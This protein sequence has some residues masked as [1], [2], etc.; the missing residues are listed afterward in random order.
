MPA[1]IHDCVRPWAV[2]QLPHIESGDSKRG[3]HLH[4]TRPTGT[5]RPSHQFDTERRSGDRQAVAGNGAASGA[6]QRGRL[7]VDRNCGRQ[8]RP[9]CRV[10][11]P[12]AGYQPAQQDRLE[13]SGGANLSRHYPRPAR[14]PWLRGVGVPVPQMRRRTAFPHRSTRLGLYPVRLFRSDRTARC[15]GSSFRTGNPRVHDAIQPACALPPGRHH[16]RDLPP[17]RFDHHLVGTP[18][19]GAMPLLRHRYRAPRFRGAPN[20]SAPGFDPVPD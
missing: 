15:Q 14:S 8:P 16:G 19:H 12:G 6:G 20:H 2:I 1:D 4:G 10:P 18:R 9:A 3:E 17:V 5:A 13:T 7:V 11:A